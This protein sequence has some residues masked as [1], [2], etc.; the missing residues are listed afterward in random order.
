MPHAGHRAV[1]KTHEVFPLLNLVSGQETADKRW[2]DKWLAREPHAVPCYE[3]NR[4]R[5]RS[6]QRRPEGSVARR[7][8]KAMQLEQR[9]GKGLRENTPETGALHAADRTAEAQNARGGEG[10]DKAGDGQRADGGPAGCAEELF[11]TW[12]LYSH[13]PCWSCGA[14]ET[15]RAEHSILGGKR[16]RKCRLDRSFQARRPFTLPF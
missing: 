7:T 9:E 4:K 2:W 12:T 6:R 16:L 8:S 5:D 15:F 11:P 14:F 3:G 13:P 1:S 10:G